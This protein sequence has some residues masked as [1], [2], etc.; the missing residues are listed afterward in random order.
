MLGAFGLA[1]ML[2]APGSG[3]FCWKDF[4]LLPRT[5]PSNRPLLF[6]CTP[7]FGTAVVVVVVAPG[8]LLFAD[9]TVIL[10]GG[11][12]AIAIGVSVVVV[13]GVLP[14]L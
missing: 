1:L 12:L 4:L 6:R 14:L 8:K 7:V 13:N 2:A 9:G 5:A 11:Q 10:F 3:L